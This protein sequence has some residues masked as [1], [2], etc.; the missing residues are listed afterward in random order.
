MLDEPWPVSVHLPPGDGNGA[1]V[2]WGRLRPYMT[3]DGPPRPVR[4]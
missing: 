1:P 4:W 3:R 2:N